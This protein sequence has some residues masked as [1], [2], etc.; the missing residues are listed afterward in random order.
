MTRVTI[1]LLWIVV[2]ACADS[3][4]DVGHDC[5]SIENMST[6]L[7]QTA[8]LLR[9]ATTNAGYL[10]M[11]T[12][13]NFVETDGGVAVHA[14]TA[15]SMNTSTGKLL[16]IGLAKTHKTGSTTMQ[17]ILLNLVD[18]ELGG[19][20]DD[21]ENAIMLPSCDTRPKNFGWPG[22]FPGLSF[23]QPADHQY[24]LI[25]HH[26]VFNAA[27][28][29]AYLK[30]KPH[31]LTTLRDPTTQAISTF[32]Y[33]PECQHGFESPNWTPNWTVH[34]MNVESMQA[35]PL[36]PV[37]SCTGRFLNPQAWNLGWYE[38]VGFT[39]IH[40]RNE[41]M[42]N[43]WLALLDKDFS[44]LGGIVVMEHYDEGLVLLMQQLQLEPRDMAY[45]LEDHEDTT[46][47]QPKI[48]P[49]EE[50]E[51]Q[52]AALYPVDRALYAHFNMTFWNHYLTQ[53]VSNSSLAQL[54][55]ASAELEVACAENSEDECP[56]SWRS[57]VGNPC[58]T[59]PAP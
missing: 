9:T 44:H 14:G 28:Y 45:I 51:L 10:D 59:N 27:R 18:H 37:D 50:Q 2:Q 43:S 36:V 23:K 35:E 57:H 19:S 6:V 29:K 7:I 46:S 58:R 26:A 56:L 55:L 24:E 17:G 4:C 16:S 5:A 32:N 30:P 54:R 13:V 48:Y 25:A 31:M 38:H 53:K 3:E 1:L 33:F 42:V 49:T 21:R 8:V 15:A 11:A 39:T 47:S 20:W 52:L 22:T 41:T 12:E 34:L 40:D